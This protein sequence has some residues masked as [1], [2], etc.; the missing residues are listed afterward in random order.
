MNLPLIDVQTDKELLLQ[1]I[2]DP[3]ATWTLWS[4]YRPRIESAVR[5]RSRL[6]H[7]DIE[8][9]V[10]MTA[11][12]FSSRLPRYSGKIDD[13]EAWACAMA[14]NVASDYLRKL[15]RSPEVFPGELPDIGADPTGSARSPDALDS[16]E[17]N[18]II[19]G[20]LANLPSGQR[21]VAE[22]RFVEGRSYRDIAD[23]LRLDPA[24]VRKRAQLARV[25]LR[26]SI[27]SYTDGGDVQP[28]VSRMEIL[29]SL[30]PPC[31]EIS[32]AA[33]RAQFLSVP[34]REA[35]GRFHRFFFENRSGRELQKLQSLEEYVARH[36]T[37]W[38]KAFHLAELGLSLGRWN[39]AQWS[40]EVCQRQSG[41]SL[42][43]FLR[44]AEL[45]RA[46]GKTMHC[47]MVCERALQR[48]WRA[49]S[50][51]H[52]QGVLAHAIGQ[53]DE[54]QAAW[55]EAS[56]LEPNN[57][58]HCLVAAEALVEQ[59]H[60]YRAEPLLKK[61]LAS[62]PGNIVA[63]NLMLQHLE[64][65]GDHRS[66]RCHAEQLYESDDRNALALRYLVDPRLS[67]QDPLPADLER[68]RRLL[69]AALERTPGF[70]PL[71]DVNAA[72]FAAEGRLDKL[73]QYLDEIS[74]SWP[75][76][77]EVWL[78]KGRWLAHLGNE[79]APLAFQQGLAL[80]P[81][82][83][84]LLEAYA[85][86]SLRDHR[87]DAFSKLLQDLIDQGQMHPRLLIAAAAGS[88]L[89]DPTAG[90]ALELAEQASIL[91]PNDATVRFG[92][93]AVLH[94]AG[95]TQR[96]IDEAYAARELIAAH[97]G[98]SLLS[99]ISR[100]VSASPSPSDPATLFEL[101]PA[102]L[103]RRKVYTNAGV[104]L[105]KTRRKPPMPMLDLN[106]C[107]ATSHSHMPRQHG[108]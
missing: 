106:S 45:F 25:S 93:A 64:T 57:P 9:I 26:C 102:F 108:V 78:I 81:R 96:C 51:L 28:V 37:G 72:L 44:N 14:R 8:D 68:S 13:V 11:L 95:K 91:E 42:T 75:Q 55:H 12:R 7:F 77:P 15:R 30:S 47:R 31:F 101:V 1:C 63:L 58:A 27:T 5:F 73:S 71:L 35:Q 53:N 48:A 61:A 17:L 97:E 18:G 70:P 83:R 3:G 52:I 23:E 19:R 62:D 56:Q 65:D 87:S 4:R 59:G 86:L 79:Y 39:E 98:H 41:C 103:E 20:A 90:L 88:A 22:A 49:A 34:G 69:N 76:C 36:P 84:E 33:V 6:Q 105:R 67:A 24:T 92:H 99:K 50:R 66:L 38:V 80:T 107:A 40:Y 94:F 100:L 46:Q 32:S 60:T 89:F 2:H 43:P 29:P 74:D 21:M 54:A 104:R 16:K 82:H 85:Y 10:S